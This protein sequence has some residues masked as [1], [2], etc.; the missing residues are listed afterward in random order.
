MNEYHYDV[1]DCQ[2][3]FTFD[4]PLLGKVGDTIKLYDRWQQEDESYEATEINKITIN[5]IDFE[6]KLVLCS[7]SIG[8]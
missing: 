3:S 5:E 2:F 7:G 1:E 6:R 4:A 8:P